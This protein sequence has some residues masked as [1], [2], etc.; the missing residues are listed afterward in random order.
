MKKKTAVILMLSI[1][2]LLLCACRDM[3]PYSL[4]YPVDRVAAIEIVEVI[5][6]ESD[7]YETVKNAKVLASVP[8]EQFQQFAEDLHELPRLAVWNDPS[9]LIMGKFIRVQY[10][11]GEYEAI[12]YHCTVLFLEKNDYFAKF[13][14]S[15]FPREAYY[16]MLEKY[17][18]Q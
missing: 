15:N 13:V 2:M 7:G 6:Q 14:W 4:Y 10:D 1:L 5:Q 8:P 3:Q 9:F 17:L 12:L 11:N 16:S 18:P